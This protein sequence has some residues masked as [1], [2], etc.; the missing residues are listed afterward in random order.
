MVTL[1][2][3][4]GQNKLQESAIITAERSTFYQAIKAIFMLSNEANFIKAS[5][6][7]FNNKRCIVL[8]SALS[9]SNHCYFTLQ[10]AI[11]V[12]MDRF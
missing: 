6:V 9:C 12:S 11:T 8:P 1:Q 3:K 4:K 5:R 7:D 10:R 2:R